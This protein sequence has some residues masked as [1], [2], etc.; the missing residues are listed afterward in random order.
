MKGLL[1]SAALVF[2]GTAAMLAQTGSGTRA[3]SVTRARAQSTTP[4]GP[5]TVPPAA[6]AAKHRAWLNK[7]CVGCHNSRTK[8]P[9]EAPVNLESA[10][11]DDLLPQAET[12]ERVLRK[13]GARAM[14][15]QGVPH[16]PEAEYVGFTTWL[17][18]SLDRAWEGAVPR[19][20]T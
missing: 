13:L 17:G 20:A 5:Q 14:P 9:P 12:W 7:N 16:P 4:A 19:A 18:A 8:S 10:S 2:A 11:L 6:E 15:P 1:T 3:P